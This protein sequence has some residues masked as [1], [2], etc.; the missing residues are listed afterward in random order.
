MPFHL[1]PISRRRFLASSLAA[2]VGALTWREA[3]ARDQS[4][5]AGRWVLLAD[6]HVAA[7]LPAR[8]GARNGTGQLVLAR[9]PG[10]DQRDAGRAGEGAARVARQGP[11]RAAGEARPGGRAPRPP[12]VVAAGAAHGPGRYGAALRGAREAETGQ[13][14]VLRPHAPVGADPARRHPPDQPAAR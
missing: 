11:R 9:L 1:P 10:P 3:V 13:G 14:A 12:V 5:D 7:G 2:G 4:G 6:S 8:L